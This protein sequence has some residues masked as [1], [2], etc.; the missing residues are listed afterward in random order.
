MAGKNPFSALDAAA[1]LASRGRSID[2]AVAGAQTRP[3]RSEADASRARRVPAPARRLT[4]NRQI[5]KDLVQ[6]AERMKKAQS[7]PGN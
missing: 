3:P 7:N 4:N 2:A 5:P 1:R 6:E